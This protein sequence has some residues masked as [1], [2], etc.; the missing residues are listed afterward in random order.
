[1]KIKVK[2]LNE[3]LK[4]I[5]GVVADFVFVDATDSSNYALYI[6]TDIQ[7]IKIPL[8]I[9]DVMD[10]ESKVYVINKVE[11]MHLIPY[12][13]ECLVLNGD[14]SYNANDCTIKGKF[15]SNDGY[16]EELESRKYLFDHEDEYEEFAEITPSILNGINSGSIFVSP[17]SIKQSERYL[18]IK[19]GK[20]FSYSK[21]RIYLNSIAIDHDGLLSNEVIKA[22][23]S[24]G[25]GTIIKSNN[26][27]YL[28]V[29]AQRSLFI[30][31]STPNG[32]DFHPVLDDKFKTKLEEVKTFN[33]I[34]INIDELKSKLDYM[35]FYSAK[36]PNN[37]TFLE[38]DGNKVFLSTDENTKV[39]M[40]VEITKNEEVDKMSIPF[41]C[42]T[43]QLVCS[44]VG[45]DCE[46]L[47]WYAS[48]KD[49][50]KLMLIV[51]GDTEETV[52]ITKINY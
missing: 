43:M 42:G 7:A 41:D 4:S 34:S 44:K 35:S 38:I 51:F 36:N 25:I 11:F 27:S 10:D 39:E 47:T 20:V 15:E 26:D 49:D 2:S 40:S 18:D 14:Y 32:I 12:V 23:Q 6:S 45:K 17:D 37:L 3:N 28:L 21:F 46:K 8:E 1:M 5:N 22:I 52:V 33:K 50:K 19:E 9:T 13:N 16:A 48:S 30:Y 24:M 29:N 31:Q